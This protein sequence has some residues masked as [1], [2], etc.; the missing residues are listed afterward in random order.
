[1]EKDNLK[2]DD[3]K[4]KSKS[5]EDEDELRNGED[6]HSRKNKSKKKKK[7]G[8]ESMKIPEKT[9]KKLLKKEQL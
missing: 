9:L 3:Q 2:R 5:I 6:N 4:R 7:K 8:L 1:M